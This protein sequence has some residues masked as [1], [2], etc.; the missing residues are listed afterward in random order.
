MVPVASAAFTLLVFC[1]IADSSPETP[2]TSHDLGAGYKLT[3]TYTAQRTS[4]RCVIPHGR[5]TDGYFL[6]KQVII[7]KQTTSDD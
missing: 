5:L 1:P 2:E 4:K 3:S 6:L 7:S